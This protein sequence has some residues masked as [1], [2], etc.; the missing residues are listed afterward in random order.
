MLKILFWYWR[1]IT[2]GGAEAG[3][4]GQNASVQVESLK[5]DPIIEHAVE[6]QFLSSWTLFWLVAMLVEN[7]DTFNDDYYYWVVVNVVVVEWPVVGC[8]ARPVGC[9]CCCGIRQAGTVTGLS[10]KIDLS[11]GVTISFFK[12]TVVKRKNKLVIHLQLPIWWIWLV[13][14]SSLYSKTGRIG[15]AWRIE[16]GITSLY[17]FSI[18]YINFKNYVSNY[19][20]N[21]LTNI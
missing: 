11:I 20:F 1:N 9:C 16:N 6:N 4:G 8:C 17:S 7:K 15:N 5:T 12:R 3:P 13:S 2:W 10:C 19:V 21:C 14:F 18:R